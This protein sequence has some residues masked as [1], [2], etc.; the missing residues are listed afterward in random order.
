MKGPSQD[1]RFEQASASA[2]RKYRRDRIICI[3]AGKCWEVGSVLFFSLSKTV[4]LIIV[5]PSPK[6]LNPKPYIIIIKFIVPNPKGPDPPFRP[7]GRR[8]APLRRPPRGWPGLWQ[9]AA[10]YT[11]VGDVWESPKSRATL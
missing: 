9:C 11:I 3:D 2:F 10:A 6:T 7:P 5:V 8:H 1:G 4:A